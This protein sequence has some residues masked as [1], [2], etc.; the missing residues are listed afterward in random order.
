MNGIST[1]IARAACRLRLKPTSTGPSRRRFPK[2]ETWAK[3]VEDRTDALGPSDRPIL[4]AL[5]RHLEARTPHALT[6]MQELAAMAAD[7]DSLIPFSDYERKRYAE[8]RANPGLDRET[9]NFMAAT[10][11]WLA[12]KYRSSTIMVMRS[13]IP[14]RTSTA[15]VMAISAPA[16]PAMSLPLP[17]M[18]PYQRILAL[19]P[20]TA[21]AIV[22]GA[23]E[24]AFTNV[25]IPVD[26]ARGFNRHRIAQF[27]HFPHVRHLVTGRDD[28]TSDITWAPYDLVSETDRKV[29]F[30]RRSR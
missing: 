7:P 14:L 20:T 6:T 15:P 1:S 17:G 10:T 23:F 9:L 16:H 13:P 3:I 8:M 29:I 22:D 25:D 19:N 30:R 2:A 21:I 27:A 12:G 4:Y 26:V 11:S 28:L 18:T 5:V 24:G